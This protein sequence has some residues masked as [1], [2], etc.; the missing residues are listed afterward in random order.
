MRPMACS[1]FRYANA[2]GGHPPGA[3]VGT[4]SWA[5]ALNC[6]ALYPTNPPPTKSRAKNTERVNDAVKM[7]R[8]SQGLL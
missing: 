1:S 7:S 8:C 4:S 6:W 2:P 5:V 3:K